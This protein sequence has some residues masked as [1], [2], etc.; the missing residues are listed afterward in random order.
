MD[1]DGI[2]VG[3][4]LASVLRLF[5]EGVEVGC[6]LGGMH[7]FGELVDPVEGVVLRVDVGTLV[8]D[9]LA[10]VEDIIEQSRTKGNDK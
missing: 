10:Q 1:L 8:L 6:V 3:I 2:A 5:G 7:V 9:A 4:E